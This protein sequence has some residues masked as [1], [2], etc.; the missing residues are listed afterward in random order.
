MGLINFTSPE[1]EYRFSKIVLQNQPGFS[2]LS[3]NYVF[4][5]KHKS[6]ICFLN[7]VRLDSDKSTILLSLSNQNISYYLN[8]CHY[9]F[10]NQTKIDLNDSCLDTI[11]EQ[12]I[13]INTNFLKVMNLK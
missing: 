2:V 10:L 3:S 6:V 1:I 9:K 4:D 8:K 11:K 12:L 7:N 5:N 13:D